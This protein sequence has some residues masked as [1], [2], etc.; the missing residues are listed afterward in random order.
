MMRPK[1]NNIQFIK[2]KKESVQDFIDL[3]QKQF[4]SKFI[5]DYKYKFIKESNFVLIPLNKQFIKEVKNFLDINLI[6]HELVYRDAI[7][8]PKFKYKTVEAFLK[9]NAPKWPINLIPKSYDII[10]SIAIIEFSDLDELQ[11]REK[12]HFKREVAKAITLVNNSVKSV[13]EKASQ[14]KGEYRLRKLK[15]LYGKD[16][17]E[18]IH[19]ENYALFKV[20]V[21]KAYFTPRLVNERKRIASSPIKNGELI[22]DM[23]AG[24]GPFS[25][26]VAQKKEVQIYSFDINSNA[27]K[28]LKANIILNHVENVVVPININVKTLLKGD[29]Q[30]GTILRNK[31]DRIIMNLPERSLNFLDV[32]CFLIK[33]SGGI[34]HNYQFCDK[35]DP[36]QLAIEHFSQNLT[37][38]DY[39]IKKILHTGVVKSYSPSSDLVSLDLKVVSN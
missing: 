30:L 23:F 14:V 33:K 17:P 37:K 24:V 28:Y 34:I 6:F 25:I 20:N 3:I 15:I 31:V 10:G 38:H 27:Y 26:Q 2:L 5:I 36:I 4:E 7:K 11:D 22:V 35:P 12:I 39:Q 9:E 16:H 1:A 8:S 21:K 29:N 32:A 18:T 13:Y 19:K